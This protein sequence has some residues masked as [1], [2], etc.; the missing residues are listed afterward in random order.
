MENFIKQNY[1]NKDNLNSWI[2][3]LFYESIN[4]YKR[5]YENINFYHGTRG[6]KKS[7]F[8]FQNSI[9]FP[10]VKKLTIISNIDYTGKKLK[11]KCILFSKNENIL[12]VDFLRIVK[13]WNLNEDKKIIFL[14]DFPKF[15][16]SYDMIKKELTIT[17]FTIEVKFVD[18]KILEDSEKLNFF[19]L[20]EFFYYNS[21]NNCICTQ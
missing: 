16:T 12:F 9:I 5:G 1:K 4:L 20:E 2:H 14:E 6:Y 21:L 13:I 7:F 19:V 3:N 8:I 18:E 17:N 10:D 15:E 11:L